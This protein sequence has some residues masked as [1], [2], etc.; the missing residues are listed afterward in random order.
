VLT[1]SSRARD[2][3]VFFAAALLPA[4]AMALFAFRALEGEEVAVRE[5][6]RLSLEQAARDAEERFEAELEGLRADPGRWT[7]SA[8]AEAVE[9]SSE[10]E[11]S[12]P[13][14]SAGCEGLAEGVRS[15]DAEAK[16][17]VLG[18]CS[19]ARTPGGRMLWPLVALAEGAGTAATELER[20]LRGHGRQLGAVEREAVRAEVEKAGWLDAGERARVVAALDDEGASAQRLARE[21]RFAMLA[22]EDR[23]DWRD[24][25]SAGQLRRQDD[26]RYRGFVVHPRSIA[27]AV[28]A[29][30]PALDEAMVARLV[31][32]AAPRAG[33]RATLLA[34]GAH[35]AIEWRDPHAVARQTA[36]SKRLLVGAAA[37]A[38][39]VAI[40]LAGLLFAR[41]RAERRLG[42]LRTDFVAAVSHELRTPIASL[43]ML[44]ELIAEDRVAPEERDEVH[45]ALVGE[46]RRLGETVDRLLGFSR[47]EAGRLSARRERV[48]VREVIAAAVETFS[49]RHP[50]A[51]VEVKVEGDL[52]GDLD[53]EAVAMALSNLLGNARKYAPEG[54]PYRVT[55][56]RRR[57]GI[58]IVVR[59]EGP[60]IARRDHVR[61]FRPF[62]RAAD[63]LSEATEG[64]GIGL[65]LV[66]HVARSHGGS[67]RVDSAP[68]RGAAFILWFPDGEER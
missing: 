45:R 28:A 56:S 59:D 53:R 23:I 37:F 15:G 65:S 21:Q 26:G 13:T 35:L 49:G 47:M 6:M 2:W 66:A 61:I 10:P 29:G 48:A 16:R 18:E 5:Q 32:A 30:W 3:G 40:A 22:G 19:G 67:V 11:E 60:G 12:I 8:I 33:A 4:L 14:A 64:S 58:E 38:T 43:R 57:R 54:Q 68:G 55:A 9:V 50:E 17:R 7:T 25:R 44:S 34:N 41:M 31:I 24:A 63:K 27:L 51:V 1:A 20:W 52:E 46:A 39:M 62:E 36:R 42:A